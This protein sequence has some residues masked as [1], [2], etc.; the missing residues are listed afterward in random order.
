MEPYDNIDL[1]RALTGQTPYTK[2]LG[3]ME[4]LFCRGM[5]LGYPT[6][7]PSGSIKPHRS[8]RGWK[9]YNHVEAPFWLLDEWCE[10]TGRTWIALL[11]GTGIVAG[12]VWVMHYE[13][14]YEKKSSPF[15]NWRSPNNIK[16][17]FWEDGDHENSRTQVILILS[18]R[19]T[20]WARSDI[21]LLVMRFLTPRQESRWGN[22]P[23]GVE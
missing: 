3:L 7:D 16:K 2:T 19:T 18:T 13:G 6:G 12:P 1:R 23:V 8:I 14:Q 11:D 21:S 17:D 9:E 5:L 15:L 4:Q 22:I 20:R 10:F